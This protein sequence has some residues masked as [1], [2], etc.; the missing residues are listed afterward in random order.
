MT[1]DEPIQPMSCDD[2]IEAINACLADIDTSTQHLVGLK[3]ELDALVP[4]IQRAK[5]LK[6]LISISQHRLSDLFDTAE[7]LA[8]EAGA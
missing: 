2:R 4:Y 6:R 3:A 7:R 8:T 1:G 5:R